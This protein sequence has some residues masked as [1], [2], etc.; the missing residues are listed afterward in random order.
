MLIS[1]VVGARP[2]FMKVAPIVQ[3]LR[4]RKLPQVLIHTGQHY[5]P[6]ISD[7]FFKDLGLPAPD[8]YLDQ[9]KSFEALSR[10]NQFLITFPSSP[11]V[12]E[13]KGYI[14]RIHE[15]L[16]RKDL[17]N[18]K[19]YLR[20]HKKKSARI[21]LDK[22]VSLFPDN[23]YWAEAMYLKG[24]MLLEEQDL[25][26]ARAMFEAVADYPKETDFKAAARAELRLMKAD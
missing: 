3:E 5:S 25:A 9:T 14:A 24:R 18:A 12:E 22:I 21:Y 1:C 4:R 20:N 13:V 6:D 11:L 23:D 26:G 7:V 19:F 8:F 17:K 15:T 16:A 10:F 2:N